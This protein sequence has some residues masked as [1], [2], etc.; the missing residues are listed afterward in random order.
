MTYDGVS[1]KKATFLA[2]VTA[3]AMPASALGS[4]WGATTTITG[5]Y[6]DP[7]AG[8]AFLKTANNQN[9]DNCSASNYLSISTSTSGSSCDSEQGPATSDRQVAS[10]STMHPIL[11]PPAVC[12][13]EETVS[14]RSSGH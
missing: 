7:A 10:R 3:C 8:I 12:A 14:V 9:M 13:T 6:I 4:G 1:M 2:I 11:S 5:F